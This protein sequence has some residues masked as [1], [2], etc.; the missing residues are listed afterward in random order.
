MNAFC[1]Q[2][3]YGLNRLISKENTNLTTELLH[4]ESISQQHIARTN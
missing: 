1:V 3:G 4:P 2:I